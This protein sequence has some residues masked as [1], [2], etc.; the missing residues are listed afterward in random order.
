MSVSLKTTSL[1]EAVYEALRES[2]VTGSAA[3]GSLMTET[4]IA[5]QYGVARPTA[6]AA[7]ERLVSEGLL[8]RQAHHAARVPELDRDDIVDLYANRALIE[9]AALHNLAMAGTVPSTALALQ[10]QLQEHAANDDRA[11]L[12]RTDIDFHRALVVAQQSPRLSRLHSLIMGEIELCIGQV[13]AHQLI[14]PSDVAEQHQGILD[15]VAVGDIAL[16]GRLTREH[17]FN[18]RDRLLR[19]FDDDHNE[20]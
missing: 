16:A 12:A 10:R 17:I 18:A 8:T 11:A 6:K 3:P 20:S 5:L 4:A 1:P 9:E 7:L 13:Q 2:I 19:K 15:A 14:R